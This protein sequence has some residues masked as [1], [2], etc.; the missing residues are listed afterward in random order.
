M[1]I[2]WT[3]SAR[4]DL[5]DLYRYFE[6]KGEAALGQAIVSQ[7]KK[8]VE[9][10]SLYPQSGRLLFDEIRELIPNDLPF[11]IYYSIGSKVEILRILHFS[12]NRLEK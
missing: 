9:R 6:G 2:D 11:C 4:D 8:S 7:L 1:E 3:E 10:L 5:H 12:Q